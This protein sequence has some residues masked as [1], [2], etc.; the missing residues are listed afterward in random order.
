MANSVKKE[1]IQT[2]VSKLGHNRDAT[3]SEF[4]ALRLYSPCFSPS[5]KPEHSRSFAVKGSQEKYYGFTL[6][7]AA[8]KRSG[9]GN[10]GVETTDHSKRTHCG[11]QYSDD[12]IFTWTILEFDLKHVRN[13]CGADM[14]SCGRHRLPGVTEP[15]GR[16]WARRKTGGCH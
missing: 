7:A 16:V 13:G 11:R 2:E 1:P 9:F 5:G 12:C 15:F 6:S 8:L 4:V 14:T 3:A 10:I